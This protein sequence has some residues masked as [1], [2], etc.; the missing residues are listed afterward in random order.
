[1]TGSAGRARTV[2]VCSFLLLR[3][4]AGRERRGA[5]PRR[6]PWRIYVVLIRFGAGGLGAFGPHLVAKLSQD[7]AKMDQDSTKMAQDSAKIAQDSTK[8]DQ[9]SP[10]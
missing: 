5:A 6:V 10:T 8:M 2:P 3:E 1:M 7:G 9:D 4:G